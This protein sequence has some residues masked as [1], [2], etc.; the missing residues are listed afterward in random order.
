MTENK[1]PQA[2]DVTVKNYEGVADLSPVGTFVF[3]ILCFAFWA[4]DLGLLGDGATTAIGFLGL[5]VFVPYLVAG[6]ALS[7][8]GLCLGGNTYVLFGAVFGSCGGL[9]NTFDAVFARAGIP[10]DYSVVGIAFTLA[11]LYLA[12]MLPAVSHT[13]KVDFFI[14]FF[15]ACGVLGSGLTVLGILPAAFN[16]FNG[17]ALFLDGVVGFYAVIATVSNSLG[18]KLPFGKPFVQP[19]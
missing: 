4:V 15:G 16:L 12:C 13:T 6:V 7:R 9:F 19:R 17:W 8:K 14:F 5:A 10:F 1:A 2:L 18:M 3:C 11:G